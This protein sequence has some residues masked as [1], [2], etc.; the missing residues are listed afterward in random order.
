MRRDLLEASTDSSQPH[1]SQVPIG[2]LQLLVVKGQFQLT[3]ESQL[4]SRTSLVNFAHALA[5][6][7]LFLM[8]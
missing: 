8:D 4:G 7:A 3:S 1:G 6:A 5:M 2:G